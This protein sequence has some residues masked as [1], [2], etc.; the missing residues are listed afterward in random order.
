V[1][2]ALGALKQDRSPTGRRDYAIWML[3]TTYGLRAGEIKGLQLSDIDWRHERLRIRHG[4]TGA[5]S[6]GPPR[7]RRNPNLLAWLDSL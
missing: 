3:L 1:Q 4:K 5:H 6:A 7:W 2:R